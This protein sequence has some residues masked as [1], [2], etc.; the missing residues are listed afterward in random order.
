[1]QMKTL[2][3]A[4]VVAFAASVQAQTTTVQWGSGDST[5]TATTSWTKIEKPSKYDKIYAM[6]LVSDGT[7]SNRLIYALDDTV[8]VAGRFPLSAGETMPLDFPKGVWR[9]WIK[10]SSG[11]I[12]FRYLFF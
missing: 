4:L 9:V 6:M 11:T 5:V 3:I 8:N 1:M 10:T 7:G 12:P 2:L